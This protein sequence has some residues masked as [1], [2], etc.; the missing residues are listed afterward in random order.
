MKTNVV[1]GKFSD[2]AGSGVRHCYD[3]SGNLLGVIRK[4]SDGTYRVYRQDGKVRDKPRLQE[5][6][7]TVARAN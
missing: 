4:L 6:F 5:A 2:V 7:R 1:Y 3:A